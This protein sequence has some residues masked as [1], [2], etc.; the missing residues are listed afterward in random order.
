MNFTVPM[1]IAD[2]IPVVFFAVA[3]VILQRDLY[4]RMTKGAF[5][6]FCAGT[7]D[8]ICAGALKALYKLLYA[9]GICDFEKL[10][11]MFF[12]VQSIGFILAGLGIISLLIRKKKARLAVVAPPVVSGTFLFVGLMV[13]GLGMMD[14]TL[15]WLSKKLGKKK[16][17]PVFLVSF[18][19]CLCMGYLSTKDFAQAYMNWIA[20]VVN[21]A[22][23]GLLLF[24]VLALHKAGLANAE[25]VTPEPVSAPNPA[26]TVI[27]ADTP[28]PAAASELPAEEKPEE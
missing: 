10:S 12:P 22:G 2:F 17:I 18:F 8:V 11:A 23:Q 16:L 21:I 9:S 1:A 28:A 5:A 24:G 6:L 26:E 19:L 20:E 14:G 4:E 3:A 7:I 15:C 27:P 25:P 13:F